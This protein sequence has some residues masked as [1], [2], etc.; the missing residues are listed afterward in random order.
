MQRFS[1]DEVFLDYIG[2]EPYF[3]EPVKVAHVIKDRV[4]KVLGFTVNIGIGENRLT[5][6]MGREQ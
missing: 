2:M 4:K 5:A 6:K 1:I 3:G